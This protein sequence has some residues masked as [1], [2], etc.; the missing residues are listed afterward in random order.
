M[1]KILGDM[2]V[3]LQRRFVA[4][5][6]YRMLCFVSIGVDFDGFYVVLCFRERR[7]LGSIILV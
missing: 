4:T 3:V 7:V 5:C 6:W 2:V 1:N